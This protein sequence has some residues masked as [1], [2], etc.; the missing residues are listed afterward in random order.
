MRLLEIQDHAEII[1]S[2]TKAPCN[3][4]IPVFT[5]W[6]TTGETN[7]IFLQ[8][9]P[10]F[11]AF[12][13]ALV[14]HVGAECDLGKRCLSALALMKTRA[15]PKEKGKFVPKDQLDLYEDI[16]EDT[17]DNIDNPRPSTPSSCSWMHSTLAT[18]RICST[19]S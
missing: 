17:V 14:N 16:N 15:V 18:S 5:R 1:E 12:L 9:Y 4:Q 2:T 7:E 11:Y 8:V 3:I 10:F 19:S 6:M 13:I